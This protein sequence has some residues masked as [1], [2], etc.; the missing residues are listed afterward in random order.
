MPHLVVM[1][2]SFFFPGLVC[3]AN[4]GNEEQKKPEVKQVKLPVNKVTTPATRAN[5]V[6]PSTTT[7]S[8]LMSTTAKKTTRARTTVPMTT[9]RP[10]G[11]ATALGECSIG[12]FF[13]FQ[14]RF[15]NPPMTIAE[16]C[17]FLQ[18]SLKLFFTHFSPGISGTASDG[19]CKHDISIIYEM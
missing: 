15:H 4:T 1:V 14:G 8:I 16:T 18:P 9:T 5:K 19:M 6:L 11:G 13:F 2:T 12:F 17:S 10:T 7:S 3:A